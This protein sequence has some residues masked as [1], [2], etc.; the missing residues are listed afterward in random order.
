METGTV[1]NLTH[2]YNSLVVNPLYKD[3]VGNN[4]EEFQNIL[5]NPENTYHLYN[6][7]SQDAL[8]KDYIGNSLSEFEQ[9]FNIFQKESEAA[10][11]ISEKVFGDDYS[12]ADEYDMSAPS[13]NTSTAGVEHD[14]IVKKERAEDEQ[15]VENALINDFKKATEK[16]R[17]NVEKLSQTMNVPPEVIVRMDAI[18]SAGVN[19]IEVPLSMQETFKQ[20]TGGEVPVKEGMSDVEKVLTENMHVP[21]VKRMMYFDEPIKDNKDGT[22]STHRMAAE[23]DEEGNWKVFP[24]LFYYDGEW[25]EFDDNREAEQFAIKHK[26]YID[27]GKDK[28]AAL[29]FAES[30]GNMDW[31]SMSQFIK[32][33]G[34]YDKLMTKRMIEEGE[35]TESNILAFSNSFTRQ[36]AHTL[37]ITD[38]A[39]KQVGLRLGM[40]VTSDRSPLKSL[41][42]ILYDNVASDKVLATDNRLGRVVESSGAIFAD[43]VMAS[44]FPEVAITKPFKM[45]SMLGGKYLPSTVKNITLAPKLSSFTQYLTAKGGLTAIAEGGNLNEITK[46]TLHG[47]EE[48]LTYDMLGLMSNYGKMLTLGYTENRLAAETVGGTLSGVLFGG[49]TLLLQPGL[50]DRSREVDWDQVFDS[51]ALGLFMHIKSGISAVPETVLKKSMAD[52]VMAAWSTGTRENIRR[53]FLLD[54]TPE[55][56]RKESLKVWNQ[57]LLEKDP[58]EQK[59]LLMQKTI[60]DNMILYSASG[61][62]VFKNREKL[63]EIINNDKKLSD[64]QKLEFNERIEQTV[65]DYITA[66]IIKNPEGARK[67]VLSNYQL[68]AKQKKEYLAK[69]DAAIELHKET[70]DVP[71]REDV[72]NKSK[73]ILDKNEQ[74]ILNEKE[75]Q[76]IDL[77][78]ELEAIINS[79]SERDDKVREQLEALLDEYQT[80]SNTKTGLTNYAEL[81]L[82]KYQYYE[83]E[84]KKS[85]PE[86]E[87]EREIASSEADIA[88]KEKKRIKSERLNSLIE[89]SDVEVNGEKVD[90]VTSILSGSVVSPQERAIA[91]KQEQIKNIEAETTAKQNEI[92][93]RITQLNSEIEAIKEEQKRVGRPSHKRQILKKKKEQLRRAELSLKQEKDRAGK[94]TSELNSEIIN[95]ETRKQNILRQN[96]TS[97][98]E[99]NSELLDNSK[100]EFIYDEKGDAIGV[101]Y[102]LDDGTKIRTKDDNV[103]RIEL[104]REVI[105]ETI[106]ESEFY[107]VIKNALGEKRARQVEQDIIYKDKE[108]VKKEL[109]DLLKTENETKYDKE[110]K[111]S[112]ITEDYHRM[113]DE[114][115]ELYD[116]GVFNK[117]KSKEETLKDIDLALGRFHNLGLLWAEKTG[118]TLKEYYNTYGANFRGVMLSDVKNADLKKGGELEPLT[119]KE[120][121]KLQN[122]DSDKYYRV[123]KEMLDDVIR[124]VK[125]DPSIGKQLILSRDAMDEIMFEDVP[126]EAKRNLLL[127]NKVSIKYLNEESSLLKDVEFADII[128][129]NQMEEI[130]DFVS[131]GQISYDIEYLFKTKS[132]LFN[133]INKNSITHRDGFKDV[134][135]NEMLYVLKNYKYDRGNVLSYINQY[136][137]IGNKNKGRNNKELN[138]YIKENIIPSVTNEYDLMHYLLLETH[139]IETNKLI[140]EKIKSLHS[141]LLRSY[142]DQL[143]SMAY[144]YKES[145]FF[146]KK[147]NIDLI[148]NDFSLK[149]FPEIYSDLKKVMGDDINIL[150]R[151]IK[152]NTPE[153]HYLIIDKL[154]NK[155]E[156]LK[157]LDINE[158]RY[159][160]VEMGD[161]PRDVYEKIIKRGED[162]GINM[163]VTFKTARVLNDAAVEYLMKYNEK[164]LEIIVQESYDK[165]ISNEMYKKMLDLH[166]K[167]I[168]NN[169]ITR[170]GRDEYIK[171][172]NDLSME[173]INTGLS[174]G[175]LSL[176]DIPNRKALLSYRSDVGKVLSMLDGETVTYGKLLQKV[177]KSK[178]D[179][180]IKLLKNIYQNNFEEIRTGKRLISTVDLTTK[181]NENERVLVE[182]VRERDFPEQTF[183]GFSNIITFQYEPRTEAVRKEYEKIIG[184]LTESTHGTH[185]SGLGFVMFEKTKD[186]AVIT[187]I[188]SDFFQKGYDKQLVDKVS[189]NDAIELSAD[190][191]RLK[192]DLQVIMAKNAI[193]ALHNKG[194]KNI[195]FNARDGVQKLNA[196]PGE[197]RIKETYEKLPRELGFKE[198]KEVEIGTTKALIWDKLPEEELGSLLFKKT[199]NG[200]YIKGFVR[201]KEG[202]KALVGLLEGSDIETLIH[203]F[204]SGHIGRR[205]FDEIAKHD[206]AF[207][208]AYRGVKEWLNVEGDKWSVTQEERF[209]EAAERYFRGGEQEGVVRNMFDSL[210]VYIGKLISKVTKKNV[211]LGVPPELKYFMMKARANNELTDT[212]IKV[213]EKFAGAQQARRS[214]LE[215]Y[216]EMTLGYT[217]GEKLNYMFVDVQQNIKNKLMKVDPVLGRRVADYIVLQNGNNAKNDYEI[218]QAIENIFGGDLA[219]FKNMKENLKSFI[220]RNPVR[221]LKEN[222]QELVMDILIAEQEVRNYVGERYVKEDPIRGDIPADILLEMYKTSDSYLRDKELY[223]NYNEKRVERALNYIKNNY[224]YSR[225]RLTRREMELLAE[226]IDAHRII[227]LDRYLKKKDPDKHSK[228]KHEFDKTPEEAAVFI[229]MVDRQDPA[230]AKMFGIKEVRGDIRNRAE[231][232]WNLHKDILNEL[233]EENLISESL[234]NKLGREQPYYSKNMYIDHLSSGEGIGKISADAGIEAL[235]EGSSGSKLLDLE[236]MVRDAI[237]R[238][239]AAIAL[240]RIYNSMFDMLQKVQTD[241][242]QIAEITNASEIKKAQKEH[243]EGGVSEFVKPKFKEAPTGMTL[244]TF[245]VGNGLER[246]LYIRNKYAREIQKEVYTENQSKAVHTVRTILGVN[247]LKA[248]AT[249]YN[250]IFAM[251]NLVIDMM[252]ILKTT[253]AYSPVMPYAMFQ[254]FYYMMKMTRTAAT[255]GKEYQD[256]VKQGGAVSFLTTQGRLGRVEGK[257]VD[258]ILKHRNP[259]NTAKTLGD[260]FSYIGETSEI[261]TRLALRERMKDKYIND[262]KKEYKRDPN[263]SEI[264][265]I[266]FRASAYARN[267]LDFN[268]GGAVIKFLDNFMPYL[269]PSTQAVRGSIRTFGREPVQALF[270]LSQDVMLAVALTAYNLGYFGGEEEDDDKRAMRDAYLNKIHSAVKATN[271]IIVLPRKFAYIDENGEEQFHYLKIPKPVMTYLPLGLIEDATAAVLGYKDFDVIN[272]K[273]YNE[274]TSSLSGYINLTNVPPTVN[275][276]IGASKGYDLF[277]N[278]PIWTGYTMDKMHKYME[279]YEDTPVRY[280]ALGKHTKMVSPVIAQYV[281]RQYFTNN[282]I[283]GTGIGVLFDQVSLLVDPELERPIYENMLDEWRRIPGIKRFLSATTY[284]AAY[285]KRDEELEK[286]YIK[287]SNKR[288]IDNRINEGIK[289]GLSKREIA[290]DIEENIISN[291][292][293]KNIRKVLRMHRT[294]K[295]KEIK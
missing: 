17:N 159:L 13:D 102:K 223:G 34:M 67:E 48:G 131:R 18:N 283:I 8:Y 149:K 251:T 109:I 24:T 113:R 256:L 221:Q 58:I 64:S 194:I 74:F 141:S 103:L 65:E 186:G 76:I 229:E 147:E 126:S 31:K 226:Y 10:K 44:A 183:T 165:D 284:K 57:F 289:Q 285:A 35:L 33:A 248:A 117:E 152:E 198:K 268:Q 125:K 101:E 277:Y 4:I 148:F 231:S 157:N 1:D 27:F 163:A 279:Y 253:T 249:G 72:E 52:K 2:L 188:Q 270:K 42:D 168:T 197:G 49:H 60:I 160:L 260:I 90:N 56:L 19:G 273:R 77:T 246:G 192:K 61:K 7:L 190:L 96:K 21:F 295:L 95:L 115:I 116:S 167:I 195:Y 51:S 143:V 219:R 262:F 145:E 191:R 291:I 45:G 91:N 14:I 181:L 189:G 12:L 108:S 89:A 200:D 63:K 98:Y 144:K 155:D 70:K 280:K 239:N 132:G 250:P 175:R 110:I 258:K 185:P 112:D 224:N 121:Y 220:R 272:E 86:S 257:E 25:I 73:E 252:H 85:I 164:V 46:K 138:K 84:T 5:S 99:T 227:E 216:R 294:K 177:G 154:E 120:L 79:K 104:E 123:P 136:H 100:I 130:L 288:L 166:N 240:N 3:Y 107:E 276:A 75:N 266:E 213:L 151:Y 269:N 169:I 215:R 261:V 93:G 232:Y 156:I 225:D 287:L 9:T 207:G 180:T 172:L 282:N 92:N 150:N 187:E 244:V 153:L 278:R 243:K 32:N 184:S 179:Q 71:T 29:A 281:A 82:T 178:K 237:V 111:D 53:S 241:D 22:I 26:D 193:V 23:V 254:Q 139:D 87:R 236:V 202:E 6:A 15:E 37:D 222:E 39:L 55:E 264:K 97:R 217:I 208:E 174:T 129:K 94:I 218:S 267:Y 30:R 119:K 171:Y 146:K 81:I 263:L 209:A 274:F 133:M 204:S 182:N 47:L 199:K 127:N 230:I 233:Y 242:F 114:L 80:E 271:F 83:S 201:F 173:S 286:N 88:V 203:E 247:V 161:L 206:P 205:I 292:N 235:K 210:M 43:I 50:Y 170:F 228:Y 293:D 38:K 265:E 135:A 59:K 124:A 214:A 11:Y 41:S 40:P 158:V 28:E 245:K 66:Q 176:S 259:N 105:N 142:A 140:I 255:K 211:S 36:F 238:K 78:S 162:H 212:E 68:E 234:K 118:R 196:S 275:A 128:W 106:S 69:I 122:R 62:L 290:I 134:T 20:M 54:K 137:A 16:Y